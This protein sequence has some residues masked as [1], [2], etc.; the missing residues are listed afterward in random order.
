M[1]IQRHVTFELREEAVYTE[2]RHPVQVE[3][4]VTIDIGDAFSPPQEEVED[5][6]LTV[7]GVD[8]DLNERAFC[9]DKIKEQA[10]AQALEDTA[11]DAVDAAARETGTW[12]GYAG[13]GLQYRAHPKARGAFA[14]VKITSAGT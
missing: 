12:T 6:Y 2:L 5:I 14:T 9:T 10:I 11:E 4:L 1:E 13:T 3:A 8:V 7:N